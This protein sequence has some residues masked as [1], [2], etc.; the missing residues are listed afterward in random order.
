MQVTFLPLRFLSFP[1]PFC[2]PTYVFLSILP[3]RHEKEEWNNAKNPQFCRGLVVAV[4][5]PT[6][7][8]RSFVVQAEVQTR[9]FF[10][11]GLSKP[12][13]FPAFLFIHL[14][15]WVYFIPLL[16]FRCFFVYG[17]SLIVWGL[18][19]E[20]WKFL[21]FELFCFMSWLC[22]VYY[23]FFGWEFVLFVS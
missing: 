17:L 14:L 23:P 9:Y 3:I 22:L 16:Y 1:R 11:L 18:E 20:R 21:G 7:R 4:H 2:A 12:P 13:I 10:A 19:I 15:L 6:S 5:R 8:G